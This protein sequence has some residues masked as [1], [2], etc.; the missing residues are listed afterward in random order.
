LEFNWFK[1]S[2]FSNKIIEYPLVNIF[3]NQNKI[4]LTW[5]ASNNSLNE[6]IIAII[7]NLEGYCSFIMKQVN[8]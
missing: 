7:D 5:I 1:I 6:G 8:F 2:K 3:Q 4:W